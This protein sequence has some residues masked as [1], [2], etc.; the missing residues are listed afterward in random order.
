[1]PDCLSEDLGSIPNRVVYG[2]LDKWLSYSPFTAAMRV[3]SSH[4]LLCGK[5]D[6][7]TYFLDAYETQVCKFNTCYRPIKLSVGNN[8]ADHSD[9]VVMKIVSFSLEKDNFFKKE[10][11]HMLKWLFC[12]IHLQLNWQSNDLQNR[13]VYVQIVE[14]VLSEVNCTFIGN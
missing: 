14:G 3:R 10:S 12:Y 2:T 6:V 8:Y 1:M 7:K 9:K 11:F 13:Q 5:P 4:V